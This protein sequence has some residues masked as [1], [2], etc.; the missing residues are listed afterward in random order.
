MILLILCVVAAGMLFQTHKRS[1]AEA[2]VQKLK[3]QIQDV[4]SQLYS[5]DI[6]FFQD[7]DVTFFLLKKTGVNNQKGKPLGIKFINPMNGAETA[8]V[9]VKEAGNYCVFKLLNPIPR[10]M[11]QVKIATMENER[12][13]TLM[14]R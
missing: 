10:G 2:E 1:E 12:G 11:F 4:T 14:L 5:M 13:L 6:D 3:A 9:P 8:M 7:G